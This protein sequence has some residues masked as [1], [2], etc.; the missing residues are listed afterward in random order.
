[1]PRT[2]KW[3]LKYDRCVKCGRD[4]V[5]HLGRGLC[6][7]CYQQETE[8]R[9]RGKEGIARGVASEKLNYK[10]LC[11]EYVNKKRS[12]SD[13]SKECNCSRQYVYKKMKE[14]YIPLRTQKQAR[15]LAYDRNKISYTIADENGNE[16]LITQGSLKINDIFFLTWSKEMAYVLGVMYTDGNLFYDSKRGTY[17]ISISQKEPEL[18]IKVLKLMD[19]DARIRH[20][21]QRGISGDL[22]FFEIA[23]KQI[24]SDLIKLGLSPN[25]SRTIEFPKIP[26]EFVR[27]F[28]RGCWDGDGS[29]YFESG[30]LRGSYT[31]GSLNFIER[32]VQELYRVGIHKRKPPL[33]KT[34]ADKMWLNYPDGRFPLKMHEEIRS[35]SYYT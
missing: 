2:K 16:R 3:S 24:Y 18:L 17:R 13:I 33:D 32:L 27:H 8:K 1:M 34:D 7:Y 6:L 11:E 21:K 28:I 20:R 14:L 15:K 5:K 29:I 4:D 35:K 9:S 25:K 23:H 12:L 30:K 22:H 10:N 26:S 19:C 31:C